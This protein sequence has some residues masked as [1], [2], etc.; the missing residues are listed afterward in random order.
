MIYVFLKAL[1]QRNVAFGNLF[2]ITPISLGMAATEVYVITVVAGNGYGLLLVLAM[3]FG[4]AL[5]CFGGIY[6]H[7]T[8]VDKEH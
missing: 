3:G 7:K 4:A 2:W 6:V 8:F 1:Q 5:G